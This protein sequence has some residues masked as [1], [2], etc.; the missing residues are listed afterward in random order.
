MLWLIAAYLC[1]PAS[2]AIALTTWLPVSDAA[3]LVLRFRHPLALL[4]LWAGAEVAWWV[5][6]C[7]AR[8]GLDRSW[9]GERQ[10]DEEIGSEER[11][12]LCK[13]MLESTRDPWDWMGAAFLPSTHKRAPRGAA[14]PALKKVK[15]ETV[16]RT[17][18]EEVRSFLRSCGGVLT[19]SMRSSSHTS[20]STRTCATSS[21]T[22]LPAPNSTR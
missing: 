16:G 18:V 3:E 19:L 14:D 17:N 1:H 6:S 9:W 10:E 21:A 2:P 20:C 11:W 13:S 7:I 15:M 5:A 8:I 4:T 22:R 12:R